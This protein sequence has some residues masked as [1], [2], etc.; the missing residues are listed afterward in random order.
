VQKK[1]KNDKLAFSVRFNHS[2]L[3]M[4]SYYLNNEGKLLKKDFFDKDS[5]KNYVLYN[6]RKALEFIEKCTSYISDKCKDAGINFV[7]YEKLFSVDIF[8]IGKPIHIFTRFEMEDLLRK[9]DDSKHNYLVIDEEGYLQ[10]LQNN[11]SSAY[12]VRFEVFCAYNNYVGKHSTLSHLEELYKM[13]L[14]GWLQYLSSNK[15]VYQ[16]Y[17]EGKYN[18]ENILAE[19]KKYY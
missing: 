12:P 10:L 3:S 11:Y 5:S 16:S 17:V 4:S 13:A 1:D 19:I 2:S 7:C 9:G 6:R 14:E 18:E 15:S 8:R